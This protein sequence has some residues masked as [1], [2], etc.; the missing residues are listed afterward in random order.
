MKEQTGTGGG[1]TRL[2]A[3]LTSPT[4]YAFWLGGGGANNSFCGLFTLLSVYDESII[5]LL[6]DMDW[7]E[8]L[9]SRISGIFFISPTVMEP[10]G[11]TGVCSGGL[12]SSSLYRLVQWIEIV[13]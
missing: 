8:V 7:V 10:F 12:I 9:I 13:H 2:L 3:W 5:D 1:G 6:E 11:T 4:W